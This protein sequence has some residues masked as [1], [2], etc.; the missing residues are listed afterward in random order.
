MSIW[1]SSLGSPWVRSR[2]RSPLGL[3][4]LLRAAL[5][6][7]ARFLHAVGLAFQRHDLGVVDQPRHPLEPTRCGQTR[8]LMAEEAMAIGVRGRSRPQRLSEDEA[9]PLLDARPS[10]NLDPAAAAH[11]LRLALDFLGTQRA[12]LERLAID[13]A[14]AL[15]A[16]RPPARARVA[17]RRA[18][19][20]VVSRC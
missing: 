13:R 4:P 3:A 11:E 14:S 2:C 9:A 17:P 1:M 15:L 10:A 20:K 12:V 6:A 16:R 8:Q 19:A 7:L 5:V 18:V